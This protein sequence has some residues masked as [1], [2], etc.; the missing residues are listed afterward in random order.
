MFV[1]SF[2]G[3]Q[4][5]TKSKKNIL[6]RIHLANSLGY[7]FFAVS[8]LTQQIWFSLLG[9]IIPALTGGVVPIVKTLIAECTLEI[10]RVR[11]FS[12]IVRLK[13]ITTLLGSSLS[14][15]FLYSLPFS[16]Y[17]VPFIFAA[18]LSLCAVGITASLK[19]PSLKNI[20]VA[21]E[22]PSA[23]GHPSISLFSFKKHFKLIALYIMVFFSY[24]LFVKFV[25][26]LLTERFDNNIFWVSYFFLILGISTVINQTV[27]IH[28]IRLN[29]KILG[30]LLCILC[31]ITMC[32]CLNSSMLLSVSLLFMILFCFSLATV[33]VES[34]LSLTAY[35]GCQGEVQGIICSLENCSYLLA[36]VIGASLTSYNSTYAI[37]LIAL[38]LLI[39]LWFLYKFQT[40]KSAVIK[41]Y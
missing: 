22:H 8:V 19:Y 20:Q 23:N 36:A 37:G 26:I 39:S 27:F 7:C 28:F 14:V 17:L 13:G 29:E 11:E 4:L 1:A 2:I 38:N 6:K 21:N 25:P 31:G 12:K 15:F 24:Y 40:E 18:L 5:D 30:I 32:M 3:K 10:D 41:S 9:L 16:S 33:Y 34:S 35:I